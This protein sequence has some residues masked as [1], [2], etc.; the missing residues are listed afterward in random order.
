MIG[1]YGATDAHF[2]YRAKV[3]K[4]AHLV[5]TNH[6][7]CQLTQRKRG[8]GFSNTSHH[9][10]DRSAAHNHHLFHAKVTGKRAWNSTVLRFPWHQE[11]LPLRHIPAVLSSSDRSSNL[12]D[13]V[14]GDVAAARTWGLDARSNCELYPKCID[15]QCL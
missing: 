15:E 14:D 8:G 3:Q 13:S 10:P 4:G 1:H 7:L 11:Q 2:R 5:Y 9:R 6:F 12:S